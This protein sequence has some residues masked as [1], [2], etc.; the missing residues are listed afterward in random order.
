MKTWHN[1]RAY[2]ELRKSAPVRRLVD[3]K[4]EE[5]L[6]EVEG[7]GRGDYGYV[8]GAPGGSDRWRAFVETR[9]FRAQADQAKNDTLLKALGRLSL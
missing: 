3:D 8:S 5:L 6:R 7:I 1:W 4:A 2:V 9:D